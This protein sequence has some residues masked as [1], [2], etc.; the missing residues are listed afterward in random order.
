[1]TKQRQDTIAVIGAGIMGLMSAYTLSRAF[2]DAHVT[3]FDPAGFPADNASFI[4]GGM[5]APYS[6][7]DHMPRDFLPAG[8]ESI[9]LWKACEQ[10]LGADFEFTQNG[11]IIIAHDEDRHLLERF[12]SILPSQGWTTAQADTLEP[13]LPKGKFKNAI[14]LNTE[15]HL[16]PRKAM[17]ALCNALPHKEHRALTPEDAARDFDLVIDCRG[18]SAKKDLPALRGVKGEIAIVRNTEFSLSRHLRL[19]HP[20]YPLYIVP[21][22]DNIFLIG[23]TII[24]SADNNK[25]SIRSGMEL[26]SALYSLHP[27]FADAQILEIR[28]GIRPS[29]P[30][31]LPH[32]TRSENIIRANGLYRHGYLFSPV[33]AQCICALARGEDYAFNHLFVKPKDIA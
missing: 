15:A 17:Q 24:E 8:L 11:S 14:S 29:F 23:A 25:V 27:S 31:N 30:D 33:M 19:M 2:P 7:L 18:M 26:L 4:A 13:V 9:A 16:H 20:R 28:A 22:A 10:D 3:I 1:M 5:L 21:R 32:I 12:K 6:E